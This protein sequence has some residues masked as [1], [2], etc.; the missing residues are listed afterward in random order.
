MN[1]TFLPWTRCIVSLRFLLIAG[2]S[3]W[4]GCFGLDNEPADNLVDESCIIPTDEIFDGGPGKDGIPALTNPNLIPAADVTY[5]AD[6]DRVVG[7]FA[8]G[9]AIA[10]PHNILWHHEIAN[11]DFDDARLAVTYCPLTG[12]SI[13]YD[14]ASVGGAEFGVSGLLYQT[15]LIMYDR[16]GDESLWAQM[17]RRGSCG[18]EAGTPLVQS[19]AVEMTWAGWR[20]LYPN[21][22]VVSQRTG[23]SRDY[24]FFP[25]GNY[26]QLNSGLIF[27][28]SEIDG[29]RAPKERVL[30]LP[31]GDGGIAYPF[32]E[33]DRAPVRALATTY[34][35]RPAVVFWDRSREAATAFYTNGATFAV[36]DGRVVDVES[37][38]AWNVAGE[39]VSGD[40]VGDRLEPID[41]A[42]VAFWFA[43]AVFQPE[44][45]IWTG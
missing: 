27:P 11:F 20:A 25:Y 34:D 3:V 5:L 15:N 33:L 14:R 37:G 21:S 16:N 40:R 42:Y 12:S 26:E 1:R 7:I 45:T 28:V 39:A 18:P 24:N 29:R 19:A 13:V 2:L 6:R 9:E 31:D 10:V 8:D 4:A 17:S 23:F 43:W 44:T 30:G 41:E 22:L 38:S 32:L 36:Q 35:G